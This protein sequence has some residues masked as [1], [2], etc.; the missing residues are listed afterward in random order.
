[1]LAAENERSSKMLIE[2]LSDNSSILEMVSRSFSKITQYLKILTLYETLP[3]PTVVQVRQSTKI[4]SR[5]FK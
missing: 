3:T 4:F 5:H 1:M 2:E